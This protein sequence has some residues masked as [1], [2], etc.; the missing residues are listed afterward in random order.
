MQAT[1]LKLFSEE[2]LNP[3]I[4]T[5]QQIINKEQTAITMDK[6]SLQSI[7]QNKKPEQ[8]F[9]NLF[10]DISDLTKVNKARQ[11]LGA[12]SNKLTDEEHE[13]FL[14][15]VDYLTNNWL[16]S[17]EKLLFEGKTLREITK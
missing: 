13:T 4:T 2:Y 1:N 8:L 6:E 9:N 3:L 7:E 17:F 12:T 16:D 14:A 10:L 11:I 5:Q 15:K